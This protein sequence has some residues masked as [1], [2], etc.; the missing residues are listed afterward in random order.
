MKETSNIIS[1][2]V[3]AASPVGVATLINLEQAGHLPPPAMPLLRCSCLFHEMAIPMRLFPELQSPAAGPTFATLAD[4]ALIQVHRDRLAFDMHALAQAQL[5]ELPNQA[6]WIERAA[7]RVEGQFSGSWW[8][9]SQRDFLPHIRA[10]LGCHAELVGGLV[11]QTLRRL[12]RLAEAYLVAHGR[13][14]ELAAF[15][16]DTLSFSQ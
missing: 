9:A 7:R 5:R 11:P 4:L 16:D 13:E 6:H 12:Q 8:E 10:L 14:E 1:V 3:S 2:S 15:G